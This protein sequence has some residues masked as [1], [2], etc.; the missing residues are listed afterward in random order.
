MSTITTNYHIVEF[1]RLA[2]DIS[3]ILR[4]FMLQ[5]CFNHEGVEDATIINAPCS[6]KNNEDSR[7]PEMIHTKKFG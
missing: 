5:S 6:T 2:K 4:L 1:V 3:L 7:N